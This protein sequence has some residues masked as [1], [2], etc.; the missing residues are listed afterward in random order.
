MQHF[1]EVL[2][3][4]PVTTCLSYNCS[5]IQIGTLSNCS[6]TRNPGTQI[7]FIPI[8]QMLIL[9]CFQGGNVIEQVQMIEMGND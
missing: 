8:L 5:E 4:S 1:Y 7:V 9:A 3:L 2:K 6:V